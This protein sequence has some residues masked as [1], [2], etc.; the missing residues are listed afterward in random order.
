MTLTLEQRHKYR[1][2]KEGG[3]ASRRDE[4]ASVNWKNTDSAIADFLGVTPNAV[5]YQRRKRKLPRHCGPGGNPTLH[6]I[7]QP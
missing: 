7:Y 5:M 4:W 1:P 2:L 3:N 6:P